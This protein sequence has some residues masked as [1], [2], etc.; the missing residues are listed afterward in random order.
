[1]VYKLRWGYLSLK[2]E[3]GATISLRLMEAITAENLFNVNPSF[4][5]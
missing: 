4:D 2:Q 3:A 5:F 1:M